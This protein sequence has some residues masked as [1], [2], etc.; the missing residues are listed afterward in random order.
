PEFTNPN[1]QVISDVGTPVIQSTIAIGGMGGADELCFMQ[2]T[3]DITHTR[4]ADLDITLQSPAGT[5][6]TV[7]TDNGGSFDDVF[8]GTR[9]Q[10]LANFADGTPPYLFND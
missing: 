8:A 6:A 9:F 3:L 4:C 7:T 2:L 5:V 10:I 1:P